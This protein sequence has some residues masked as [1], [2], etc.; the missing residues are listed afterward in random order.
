MPYTINKRIDLSRTSRYRLSIQAFLSG[1]SFA[2]LD[3]AAARCHQLHCHAFSNTKDHNDVY[4]EAVLWCQKHPQLKYLY[5]SAQCVYCA[6]TFTFVPES[7]FDPHKAAAILQSVYAIND[8]DEVHFHPLPHIG[9]TCI[10]A[11]P[12]SIIAPLLRQQPAIRFYSIAVPLIQMATPLYGHTRILYFYHDHFLYLTLMR[13]QQLLLCNAYYA[14]DC[15]TALYFLFLVLQQWQLN[16]DS[17]RLYI[18]GQLSKHHR[19]TLLH[20]FPLISILTHDAISL[21][22]RE[23]TL[24]YGTILHTVCAS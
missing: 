3:E 14:P 22:S 17:I 6:P 4:S 1:F 13:E 23:H 5:A 15:N 20:Y 11:I 12:N 19:Q 8:L 9:A 24:H 21:P 18:S 7:L 16:P 10:Y 2:I